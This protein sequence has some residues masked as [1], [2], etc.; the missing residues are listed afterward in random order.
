MKVKQKITVDISLNETFVFGC[1]MSYL[2]V[3]EHTRKS[4]VVNL[5]TVDIADF[6]AIAITL[7]NVQHFTILRSKNEVQWKHPGKH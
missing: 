7:D 3:L 6:I 5:Q 2:I 4:G 1:K